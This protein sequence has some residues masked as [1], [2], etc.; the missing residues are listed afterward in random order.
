MEI[1]M[2]KSKGVLYPILVA[3]GVSITAFSLLGIAIVT[4]YIPDASSNEHVPIAQ[5]LAAEVTPFGAKQSLNEMTQIKQLCHECG[6]VESIRIAAVAVNP[7][8]LGALN[9]SVASD[10]TGSKPVQTISNRVNV[11]GVTNSGNGVAHSAQHL[12]YVVHINMDKGGYRTFYLDYQP[13][14]RVG[15][16]VQLDH[17]NPIAA[18]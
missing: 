6:V 3:S 5:S 13:D 1:V 17:G 9:G 15:E 10:S 12:R 8:G 16:R 4:G 14:Y 18:S 7:H 11:A 2:E